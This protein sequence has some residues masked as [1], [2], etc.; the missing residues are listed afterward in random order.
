[1][2]RHSMVTVTSL[3]GSSL[4]QALVAHLDYSLHLRKRWNRASPLHWCG[5]EHGATVAAAQQWGGTSGREQHGMA[6]F[7][8]VFILIE[9]LAEP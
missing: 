5:R 6:S 2:L 3:S 4:H 9:V 7:A 1:M 8:G